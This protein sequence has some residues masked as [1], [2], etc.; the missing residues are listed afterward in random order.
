MVRRL[1]ANENFQIVVIASIILALIALQ[2]L[3]IS[4]NASV[5]TDSTPA[6][7]EGLDTYQ[8]HSAQGMIQVSEVSWTNQTSDKVF[9]Q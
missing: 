9:Q 1:L 2:L 3:D 4:H 8:G 5:K 7:E 6:S